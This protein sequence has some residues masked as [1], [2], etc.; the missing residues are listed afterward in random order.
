MKS[1]RSLHRL[2]EA[3]VIAA[4]Y[5]ALTL[6]LPVLSF[7]PVQFRLSEALTILPVFTPAAI[8]GLTLGCVLANAIGLGVGANPAGLMDIAFGSVATLL[9]ALCS[10]GLR[11]VRW[12]GVPVLST[13]PP[14]FFNAA[15]IGLELCFMVLGGFSWEGFG[16]M[17]AEVGAGE[18]VVAIAGGVIVFLAIE[19]TGVK[20]KLFLAGKSGSLC[21]SHDKSRR[22]P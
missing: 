11:N 14:V 18:A 22:N 2:T 15:I 20:N 13:I 7:G 3:G 16:L 8:P 5:A 1:S 10:Y 9:A 12:F 4:L 6:I 17:A 21:R 19:K